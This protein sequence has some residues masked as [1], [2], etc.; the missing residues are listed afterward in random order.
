MMELGSGWEGK[1]GRLLY[2]L[3]VARLPLPLLLA[4]PSAAMLDLIMLSVDRFVPFSSSMRTTQPAS[5]SFV[6]TQFILQLGIFPTQDVN[7]EIKLPCYCVKTVYVRNQLWLDL[8][9]SYQN[10]VKTTDL[11]SKHFR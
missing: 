2:P 8:L 9:C 4:H 1:C 10:S 5:H 6:S 3:K 7:Y 11:L